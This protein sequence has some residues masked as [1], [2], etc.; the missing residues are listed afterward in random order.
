M[1]DILC[2]VPHHGNDEEPH[3]LTTRLLFMALV[4]FLIK[5]ASKFGVGSYF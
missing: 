2:E 4:F 1:P 5:Y 3:I